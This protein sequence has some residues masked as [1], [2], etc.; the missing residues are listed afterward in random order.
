MT[1]GNIGHVAFCATCIQQGIVAKSACCG[2]CNMQS[3]HMQQRVAQLSRVAAA[4]VARPGC[5]C[6][7]S[8]ASSFNLLLLLC[9]FFATLKPVAEP[10]C[11]CWHVSTTAAAL[12]TLTLTLA[13]AAAAATARRL[14]QAEQQ[15]AI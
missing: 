1:A 12:L 4:N 14:Q 5:N 9:C 11:C 10:R 7:Q 8:C 6:C 3:M 2:Q 15:F 13:A